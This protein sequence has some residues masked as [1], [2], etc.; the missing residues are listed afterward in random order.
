MARRINVEAH[1]SVCPYSAFCILHSAF[2]ILHYA[3]CILHCTIPDFFI[4]KNLLFIVDLP[5]R[6]EYL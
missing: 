3:F 2:C 6:T 4:V 5:N 1:L